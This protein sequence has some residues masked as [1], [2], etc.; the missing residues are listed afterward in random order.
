MVLSQF[1]ITLVTLIKFVNE[2]T[3]EEMLIY[4]NLLEALASIEELGYDIAKS[5]WVDKYDINKIWALKMAV[6][7]FLDSPSVAREIHLNTF[8]TD[9][10]RRGFFLEMDEG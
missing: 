1:F 10:I 9:N 3:E 4:F 8:I 5:Q 6:N 7:Y 2:N